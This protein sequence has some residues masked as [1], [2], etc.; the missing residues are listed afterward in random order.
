MSVCHPLGGDLL[1]LPVQVT[2]MHA[3]RETVFTAREV[4]RNF[5]NGDTNMEE[6]LMLLRL[7]VVTSC[8]GDN[9]FP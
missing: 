9:Q 8:L 7:P 6:Q 4:R 2:T 5:S 3:S 1:S